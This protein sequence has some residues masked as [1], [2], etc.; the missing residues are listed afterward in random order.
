MKKHILISC[1]SRKLDRSAKAKDLYTSP[2]FRMG[3]RYARSLKPN[4]IFVLS[5][6]H[7]LI[8]SDKVIEPYNVT[9]NNMRAA[10]VKKWSERVLAQ[11]RKQTDLQKDLFIFLAGEK[12]RK[13]LLPNIGNYQV[14]ME[15]LRI[16]KQLSWLKKKMG[17]EHLC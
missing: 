4:N 6:K 14:P 5:A 16:G 2:L 1:V 13:Y 15:G 10:D 9:L 7:G 17:D 11:L 3:Y 12:Y 8:S